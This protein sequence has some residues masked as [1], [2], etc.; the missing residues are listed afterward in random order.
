MLDE[1]EV[2]AQALLFRASRHPAYPVPPARQKPFS[3]PDAPQPGRVVVQCAEPVR[4]DCGGTCEVLHLEVVRILVLPLEAA[5]FAVSADAEAVVVGHVPGRGKYAGQ[6]GAL[7]VALPDGRRLRLGS[8]LPDAVRRNPPPA[9]TVVTYR[10]NG[11]HASGLPRFARF[12]R[13]RAHAPSA[14]NAAAA[15]GQP[16]SR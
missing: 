2:G 7:L 1:H 11:T 10:F 9:G 5:L 14:A 8:G 3:P 12:W 13:V 15:G 6:T 4:E 16:N